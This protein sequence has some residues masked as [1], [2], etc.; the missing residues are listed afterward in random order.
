MTRT[1]WPSRS[2]LKVQHFAHRGD[3]L[4]LA[5]EAAGAGHAAGEVAFVG[6]DDVHSARA[7]HLDIFLRRRVIPHVD[8]HRRRDDDR[9]GGGEIQRGQKIVGDAA[10][11]FGEDVGG[12]GRDE[13]EIGALRDGDVFDGAVEIGFAAGF[14]GKQIG[15]DFLAAERGEGQR[16]D[17]FA[18]AAGHHDLHGEAVLSAGGGRVRRP[19][20]PRRRRLRRE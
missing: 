10:R 8:V 17:E 7:Q 6:I 19:C 3:D 5:G 4:F 13:Q 1:V 12:G 20:R 16:R 14:G 9:R 15:D 11:E 2:R 18:R